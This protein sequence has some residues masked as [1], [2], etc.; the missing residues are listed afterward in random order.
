MVT[1]HA[2]HSN[3]CRI[4]KTLRI[5]A[6]MAAAL[7]DQVWSLEN[8]VS[9]VEAATLRLQSAALTKEK[10]KLTDYRNVLVFAFWYWRL[11]ARD[12][13]ARDLR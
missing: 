10:F 11:D 13:H 3:F 7:T 6:A 9:M 12:L 5:I 4:H 8:I 2:V 1:I